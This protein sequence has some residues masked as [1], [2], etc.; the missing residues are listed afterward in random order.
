MKSSFC[1]PGDLHF[2]FSDSE[3]IRALLF[4]NFKKYDDQVKTK[5]QNR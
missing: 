1:F 3:W 5:K 2:M 4:L